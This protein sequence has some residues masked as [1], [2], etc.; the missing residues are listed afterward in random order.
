MERGEST[1]RFITVSSNLNAKLISS[2]STAIVLVVDF[3]APILSRKIASEAS[4]E[5][6]AHWPL[7]I[8][9]AAGRP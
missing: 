5:T 6:I 2:N 8:Q 9:F 3:N 7:N 1:A 4:V